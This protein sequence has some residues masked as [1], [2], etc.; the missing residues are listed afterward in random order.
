MKTDG[1][2]LLIILVKRGHNE[3]SLCAYAINNPHS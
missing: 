1:K 2:K 3:F